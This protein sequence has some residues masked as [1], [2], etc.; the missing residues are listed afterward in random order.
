[1]AA[2]KDTK[3][4]ARKKLGARKQTIKDLSPGG[5]KGVTGG[6]RSAFEVFA[7]RPTGG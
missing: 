6:R 5:A 4:A 2:K 1:M 7:R 3:S